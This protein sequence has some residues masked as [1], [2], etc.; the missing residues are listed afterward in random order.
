M[1]LKHLHSIEGAPG[2]QALAAKVGTSP[3]YLHQC[4]TGP[5][6]PSPAMAWRLCAADPRLVFEELYI[7]ARPKNWRKP[8]V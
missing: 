8:K 6:M 3:K 4:A 1:N 7:A 5:R 2:L